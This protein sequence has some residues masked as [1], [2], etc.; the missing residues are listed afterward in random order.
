VKESLVEDFQKQIFEA[1][2]VKAKK[3][4]VPVEDDED[5]DDENTAVENGKEDFESYLLIDKGKKYLKLIKSNW[6][7]C[8]K[9]NDTLYKQAINEFFAKNPK[10][11]KLQSKILESI[12]DDVRND[13]P[14]GPYYLHYWLHFSG[15]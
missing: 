7:E 8:V 14:G 9:K 10:Y 1:A 2:K 12:S 11:K 6:N 5:E 3:A 13:G 4:V 15:E